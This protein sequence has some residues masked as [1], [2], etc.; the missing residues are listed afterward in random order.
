MTEF[1]RFG[2]GAALAA[3]VV[4]RRIEVEHLSTVRYI[5][6]SSLRLHAAQVLSEDEISAFSTHVYTAAYGEHLL[7]Q[8]L[9]GAFAD[10][11]LLG[12]AGW[13]VADDTGTSVR[14]RSI[15]VR[16]LFTGMGLGR[17]LVH[18]VEEDARAAGFHAFSVR[19]TLNAAPFFERLGYA[20]TSHG[21]RPLFGDKT[22]PV[23]FMRKIE[24]PPRRH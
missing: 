11:E 10:N 8:Q 2:P 14:L 12:T 13:T 24:P 7:R 18:G 15:F 4:L 21:V 20:V 22:L 6:A 23:A 9:F 5:H 16:P 17:R 19:A 3:A 1:A